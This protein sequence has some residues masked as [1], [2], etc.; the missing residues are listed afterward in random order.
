MR[1]SDRSDLHDET[2][3]VEQLQELWRALGADYARYGLHQP[4]DCPEPFFEGY[5]VERHRLGHVPP[6]KD[7]YVRKWCQ[8]RANALRRQ[9]AV[10]ESFTPTSIRTIEVRCC[11]VTLEPLTMGT[12]TDTDWS[13]DRINNN[14]AYTLGNVAVMSTRANHAKSAK[15]FD[16]VLALSGATSER[17]GLEPKQWARLAA[18]MYGPAMFET[19]EMMYVRQ[20]APVYPWL[21]VVSFQE[22]QDLFVRIGRL[23]YDGRRMVERQLSNPDIRTEVAALNTLIANRIGKLDSPHDVWF[24]DELFQRVCMFVQLC[25]QE[26]LD[27]VRWVRQAYPSFEIEGQNAVDLR[28]DTRGFLF[29]TP[30]PLPKSGRRKQR[31]H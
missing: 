21:I 31:T 1:M 14:F 15:G 7:V 13:I 24:D 3:Q 6:T 29:D 23:P 9:R 25:D 2:L 12:G 16:E 11:P 30:L 20:V 26:G 18:L 17:D 22:L 8:L 10:A 19:G 5:R 28:Q 27:L 4:D